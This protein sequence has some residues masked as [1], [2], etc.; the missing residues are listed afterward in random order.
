MNKMTA[1]K[2]LC[3]MIEDRRWMMALAL[4]FIIYHLSLSRAAAQDVTVQV[5]PIQQVL[6]PQA[7]QYIDNPGKFFRLRL[8]NNTDEVQ[9]VHMGMHIDMTFPEEQSMVVTNYEHIPRQPIVLAPRQSKYLNPVEMKQLFAHFNLDEVYIRDGVYDDYRRGIYGLLPEG[10]Y[11][12]SLQC[13]KWDPA[14]TSAVMLN[15]PDDGT[16]RFTVCYIAQAPTF[17]TPIATLDSDPMSMLNVTKVN[18]N[19][20]EFTWT[21]PTLNC[22]PTLLNCQYSVKIVKLGES[23]PDEAIEHNATEYE[24]QQLTTPR[25]T[26]PPA[27]IAKMKEEMRQGTV[28]AM[29]VTAGGTFQND[30]M[31]NFSVVQNGL[32]YT[33]IENDGKSPILLFRLYDPADELKGGEGDETD[34]DVE[35]GDADKDKK[36]SLY[37]FEQPTLTAPQFSKIGTRK[38]FVGD[39][40]KATWRKAWHAGGRGEKQDTIQFRYKFQ[41]FKGDPAETK[42]TIV[43]TTKPVFEHTFLPKKGFKD[44]D[45]KDSVK[46]E[47]LDGKVKAGDYM[48]LRVSAEPLDKKLSLRMLPD[49]ANII[50]FA[51]ADHF[52]LDWACGTNTSQVEN[53]KLIDKAPEKGTRIKISDWEIEVTEAELVKDSKRLKGKGWVDWDCGLG[54]KV[55]VAVKFDNLAVNT[56][57]VCFDGLAQS[58]PDP[59][60]KKWLSDDE[61]YSDAA[62]VDSLQA[63]IVSMFSN[64]GLDNIWGD[65]SLPD[66]VAS[67]L[68]GSGDDMDKEVNNVA[69]SYEV[70]KY[71]SWYK[72][73]SRRWD[74]WKKGNLYEVYFPAEFPDEISQYFPEDFSLQVASMMFAPKGACMNVIGQYVLPK[75]NVL[76]SDLLVFGAPRLCLESGRFLPQDGVLALLSNFRIKDPDSDFDMTFLAPREPLDPKDGCFIRWEGRQ[77]GGLGIHAALHIPNLDR[78]DD[79]GKC[80]QGV[81][82]KAELKAVIDRSWGDWYGTIHMD[83]FQVRDLPGWTFTVGKDIVYD[84]SYEWNHDGMPSRE[85]LIADHPT[86]DP[87]LCGSYTRTDWRAWQGLYVGEVSLGFPKWAV[88]GKGDQGAKIGIEDMLLDASGVTLKV[89]ANNVMNAQ[90]G[91]AGGWAFDIDSC[92]VDVVQNNFDRCRITGKFGVPLFGVKDKGDDGKVGYWCEIRH[93]TD[94][95]KTDTYYTYVTNPKTGKEEKIKHQRKTYT[96]ASR[97][98]YLFHT[99]QLDKLQMNFL[100]ADLVIDKDQTF[101]ALAAEEDEEGKTHTDVELCMGGDFSIFGASSANA[102]LKELS[103]DLPINI[104]IP[105]IHFAKLYISNFAKEGQKLTAANNLIMRYEQHMDNVETRRQKA[106]EEWSKRN[107]TWKKL[108]DAKETKVTDYCFL[109]LGEWSLASPEK[110]LGPFKFNL[111]HITPDFSPNDKELS[112][113]IDGTIGLVTAINLDVGA[114]VKMRSNLSWKDITDLSSYDLSY[115]TTDFEKLSLN[116]DVVKVLHFKGE[117]EMGEFKDKNGGTNKGYNGLLDIDIIGLFGMKCNGGFFEHKAA[118]DGEPS[119]EELAKMEGDKSQSEKNEIKS[120]IQGKGKGAGVDKSSL[121]HSGKGASGKDATGSGTTTGNTLTSAN[122]KGAKDGF[123]TTSSSSSTSSSVTITAEDHTADLAAMEDAAESQKSDRN[124]GWGYFMC[125]V[126]GAAL[127]LDPVVFNRITGGF[128]FNCRP[129]VTSEDKDTKECR[130][131]KPIAEY[132]NIGAS[133]GIGMESSA[134]KEVLNADLD[135][136]VVYNRSRRCLST[137]LFQ[138]GV[139]ALTGMIKADMKLLYLNDPQDRFLSLDITAETSLAGGALGDKLRQ[140]GQECS[141]ELEVIQK[142]LDKF[143]EDLGGYAK[144]AIEG[145]P[146]AGLT[147]ALADDDASGK[148]VKDSD[149]ASNKS[150]DAKGKQAEQKK[151]EKTALGESRFSLALKITWREKGVQNHPEKWHLYLGEPDKSKRCYYQQ[152]KFKSKIVSVDI[153]ADGYLCIGN[154]LPGNGKLPPI[155]DEITNFITPKGV[156]TGGDMAKAERSRQSVVNQLLGQADCKGGV[157]TGASAWGFIDIDLGLFYGGIRA[158][159]GFDVAL[160]NYGNMAYCVNLGRSMGRN[161]WYAMGQF[162][163]Y[164]AAKFGLHIKLGKLINKKIDIV[165]AGIG[166]VFQCGL[167]SPS[168]IEGRARVK[169]RLLGG[170]VNMNKSFHFDCGQV[171]VPFKGNALDGFELFE[172]MTVASDTLPS[173]DWYSLAPVTAAE[174]K[175]MVLTTKASLGAQYRLVDPTTVGYMSTETGYGEDELK[176]A[177]SRTYIFDLDQMTNNVGDIAIHIYDLS[178]ESIRKVY[179]SGNFWQTPWRYRQEIYNTLKEKDLLCFETNQE[180]TGMLLSNPSVNIWDMPKTDPLRRHLESL[181]MLLGDYVTIYTANSNSSGHTYQGMKLNKM[182]VGGVTVREKRGS[183]YHLNLPNLKPNGYYMMRVVGS[184]YEVEQGVRVWPFYVVCDANGKPVRNSRIKW[185]QQKFYFFRTAPEPELPDAIEDLQPYVALA[186]PASNEGKL[187]NTAEDSTEVY[188]NDLVRPVIALNRDISKSSYKNGKLYWKLT[189]T[190]SGGSSKTYTQNAVFRSTSNGSYKGMNIQAVNYFFSYT[191]D[192]NGKKHHLQLLYDTKVKGKCGNEGMVKPAVHPEFGYKDMSQLNQKHLVLKEFLESNGYGNVVQ[193]KLDEIR[194]KKS[195]ADYYQSANLYMANLIASSEMLRTAYENYLAANSRKDDCVKDT[196]YVLADLHLLPSPHTGTF[197]TTLNSAKEPR[198]FAKLLPYEEP[199]VGMKLSKAPTYSYSSEYASEDFSDYTGSYHNLYRQSGWRGQ[200]PFLYFAWL[201]NAVFIGGHKIAPYGFDPV[202]VTHASETLTFNYNGFDVQGQRF[203][204]GINETAMDVRNKMFNSWNTWNYNDPTVPAYPLPGGMSE[205][206][207]RTMGNQTGNVPVWQPNSKGFTASDNEVSVSTVGIREMFKDMAAPYFV[208]DRLASK[209]RGAADQLLNIYN[210]HMQKRK[211]GISSSLKSLAKSFFNKDLDNRQERIE[212]QSNNDYYKFVRSQLG[213]SFANQLWH[214]YSGGDDD[215]LNKDIAKWNDK[216]RGR[217]MTVECRGFKVKVPYYQFPLL[218]GDC[219]N[220]DD[221][222]Q[223][224]QYSDAKDEV[225]GF[226]AVDHYRSF[227]YSVPNGRY[228]LRYRWDG[229][230]SNMMFFGLTDSRGNGGS[231]P[232]KYGSDN[233]FRYGRHSSS[234]YNEQMGYAGLRYVIREEMNWK[235]LFN[236]L[237]SLPVQAYRVNAY[238]INSGLYFYDGMINN[239]YAQ[240]IVTIDPLN[241]K[242]NQLKYPLTILW[243]KYVYADGMSAVGDGEDKDADNAD[244]INAGVDVDEDGNPIEK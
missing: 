84:H 212:V 5:T 72:K 43:E 121:G 85:K 25:L 42:K 232:F 50:D 130:Y 142:D 174:A 149:F 160:V 158:I 223:G 9:Q 10:Q 221:N 204:S 7:G 38:L 214:N 125:E 224:T 222:Y 2:S 206:Y 215:Q 97:Y 58:Y 92:Y 41:L 62:A 201:S 68:S 49:S 170:L 80:L 77:Y 145:T 171:C 237:K 33:L 180:M 70:G 94:P 108:H 59:E 31:L 98:A 19:N 8:L 65:L 52:E 118:E 21:Q 24:R 100:L 30:N 40:I 168:W 51:M 193:S 231:I 48:V 1:T 192:F 116:L 194:S 185:Q 111:K 67:V 217:Y 119:Q 120:A 186:F 79:T 182:E 136:T 165:D 151:K 110:K 56:D 133:L 230:V 99:Q 167:P 73:A 202:G 86:Y 123:V 199:F 226:L 129:D 109:N 239:K 114:K 89:A 27:Y 122:G 197:N 82:P 213:A 106:E 198:T 112:V 78:V 53:K 228:F 207:E 195:G 242:D 13:Y 101:I 143:K 163:A 26:I 16:C 218:F 208:A 46:W 28:Y 236:E 244:D 54:L 93:L 39:S 191:S 12:L 188:F 209:M 169:L 55:R 23:T 4:S 210:E 176:M 159:A 220:Y 103:K 17:L 11:K 147:D 175:R 61:T 146:Y 104:R 166:G 47:K 196:T 105:G 184:G 115:K 183:T 205:F 243:N 96:D 81:E 36:D 35:E 124:Y 154:E 22:N 76:D 234:S 219:F 32:N 69:K 177:G 181:Q 74:E 34:V 137:F 66:D 6:P 71:Y 75:S 45:L 229:A 178:D 18:I 134:G 15:T 14:I 113:T 127:R 131:G 90:T 20:P 140:L 187:F 37:V 152:V 44:E 189:S 203:I 83:P 128:Y 225:N 200:D 155:P 60:A 95:S 240:G 141:Q 117:L 29:Q 227:R 153:G 157:M 132:G 150:S 107:V 190:A 233:E 235:N 3:S 91:S 144:E 87:R 64:W 241:D 156:D 126:T 173:G 148:D 139:K 88:F 57:M 135:L 216:Y 164:L 238:D 172:D 161:G 63:G 211:N 162:Y 102:K 179:S 138:G